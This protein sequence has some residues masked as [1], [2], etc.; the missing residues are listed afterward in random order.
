[1]N[2]GTPSNPNPDVLDRF[3]SLPYKSCDSVMLGKPVKFRR[4]PATVSSE[5]RSD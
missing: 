5:G 1:M 2:C 3:V 4:G